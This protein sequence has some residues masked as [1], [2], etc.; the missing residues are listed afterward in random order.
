MKRAMLSA[1]VLLGVEQRGKFQ[2][3]LAAQKRGEQR[4][5]HLVTE[6]VHPVR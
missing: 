2:K 1:L 5:L 3:V 6:P 4:V